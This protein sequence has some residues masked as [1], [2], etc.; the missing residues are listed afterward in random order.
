MLTDRKIEKYA[1]VLLWA[2]KMARKGRYQKEDIVLIRYDLPGIRLAEVLQGRLLE[3]GMHPVMRLGL[4]PT[5]ER[6]L[7]TL[8][9]DNQIMF[10]SPGEKALCQNLN[11]SFYLHAPVSLTHLLD[12]DPKKIGKAAIAR[13]F[14]R[15][16][17]DKRE[18]RGEFGWTLSLLP[19]L[20]LAR[21]SQLSIGGY[22]SQIIKACFLDKSDP[23]KEWKEV[24]KNAT[25]IKKWL[26]KMDVKAF[27]VESDHMDL[28][29]VPG[30]KRR[31]IGLSGHNIPSF[32][33]FTS[34]DC[35]GT[36]GTYYADQPSFRSGQH[37]EGVRL[38]FK[39][40]AAVGRTAQKGQD[41]LVKQLRLDPGACRVGEFSLTDRR[42]S[43]ID[44]FMAN[45]LFDENYGGLYGNCHIALGSSYSDTYDGDPSKL[46]KQM[47][48]KLGFNDSALHWDLVNTEN[49]TVSAEL[50]SGKKMV[51]YENG[52]FTY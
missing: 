49:K 32:E 11:G 44:R 28:K 46:T 52:M 7:F 22:T 1:D 8:A 48:K 40:G 6:N 33:L 21:H 14:L 37:V 31:W 5:M 39:E 12:V 35:R 16:I 26:N 10:H 19:T 45:T 23:V 34:P 27:Y 20:E 42:F 30:N 18:A 24:Y 25:T 50:T 36:E 43:R 17:L 41:F 29:I 4:T 2:L 47:K 3:M 51:I 9:K 13:K 15:D 38:T